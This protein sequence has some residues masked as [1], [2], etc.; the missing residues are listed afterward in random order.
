MAQESPKGIRFQGCLDVRI[1]ICLSCFFLSE[2]L[3][4]TVLWHLPFF[5]LLI[6]E[7]D[8]INPGNLRPKENNT[9][10][11]IPLESMHKLFETPLITRTNRSIL[12]HGAIYQKQNTH[13]LGAG[14]MQWAWGLD[15]YGVEEG[16]R[17]S[18]LSNVIETMTWNFLRA[19]GIFRISTPMAEMF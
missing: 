11:A 8:R 1:S 15:D 3:S 19:C 13:V 5:V 9:E 2:K 18:R 17:P 6:D 12:A 10:D 16:A 7:V 4:H 14:T